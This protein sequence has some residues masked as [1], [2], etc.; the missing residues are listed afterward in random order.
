MGKQVSKAGFV[1]KSLRA[2]YRIFLEPVNAIRA[3]MI[4]V[5]RKKILFTN[6]SGNYECN[7]RYICDEILRRKLPWTIVWV[8]WGSGSQKNNLAPGRYPKELVLRARYTKEFY[9]DLFSARVI[10]DNGTSFASCAYGKKRS[11]TLI[12]TWH[13]SLGIKR[14]PKN[15]SIWNWN[16]NRIANWNGRMTDIMISNS[17]FEEGYYRET[18]FPKT[19]IRRL[20]HARNDPLFWKDPARIAAVRD[21]VYETYGIPKDYRICLY[22]PTF[23]DD[24]DI[25]PYAIPYAK[26]REALKERFGGE[27]VVMTRF[28]YRSR[29]LTSKVMIPWGVVSA[30]DYPDIVD[31]MIASDVGI[32]DYSSWICEYIHSGKPGFLYATDV[33]AYDCER[34]F[35]DPL[36]QMPFPFAPDSE[37][38]L[39]AVKGF[40]ADKYAKDCAA[41]IRRKDCMDDGHAAERIVDMLEEIMEK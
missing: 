6:F 19:P 5:D 41:F 25:R 23:R 8:V 27:W 39:S 18:Y 21:K 32:T 31:L 28:H 15:D 38:L 12:N 16:Y 10:V 2:V 20:G 11:Q 1:V 34:G 35:Y 30:T 26:L 7:A 17:A 9:R 13:G 33:K 29:A 40:D 3:R 14:F 22:A 37:A 24:G 4:P 36:D